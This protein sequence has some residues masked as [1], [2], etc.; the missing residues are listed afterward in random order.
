MRKRGVNLRGVSF[1][2]P[3][4]RL[5]RARRNGK[6]KGTGKAAALKYSSKVVKVLEKL[7]KKGGR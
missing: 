5:N 3:F 7:Q 6:C 4:R 2:K 1:K